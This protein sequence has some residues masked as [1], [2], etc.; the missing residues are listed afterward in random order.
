MERLFWICAAGAAGTAMRYGIGLWAAARF[1]TAWPYGTL[2]VNVSGC[3]AMGAL[4]QA[5]SVLAWPATL[6]TALAVG[7][8]GG[9]TTYSSFNYETMRLAQEG[10]ATAAMANVAATLAGGILA[11]WLGMLTA[12]A[13]VG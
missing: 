2:I 3:F 1:G 7:L 5:S 9:F 8:L 10:A 13:L 12:R 6:R 11:G 4:V